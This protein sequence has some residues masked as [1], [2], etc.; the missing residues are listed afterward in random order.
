M[1]FEVYPMET[2]I[3]TRFYVEI[4]RNRDGKSWASSGF[5]TMAEAMDFATDMMLLL[6]E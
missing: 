5:E 1:K 6:P 2:P 3:G 4:Y